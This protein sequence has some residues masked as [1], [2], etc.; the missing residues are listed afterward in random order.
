[1]SARPAHLCA[2][3][4]L[5]GLILL[6]L[7]WELWLAPLRPGGSWIALKALPLLAPLMGVLHGRIYTYQ[8]SLLLILAYF[9]EGVVRAWSDTGLSALLAQLEI[10]LAAVFFAAAIAY[11]RCVT[12]PRG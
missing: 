5:A 10:G 6:C 9:I 3:A 2:C 1:M 8:W 11:V 4:A 7:A 12:R